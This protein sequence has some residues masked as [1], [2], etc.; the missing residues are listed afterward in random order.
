MYVYVLYLFNH[1]YEFIYI[2]ESYLWIL[3]ACTHTHT[4]I[5]VEFEMENTHELIANDLRSRE[6][7]LRDKSD[8]TMVS[9]LRSREY[10][11]EESDLNSLRSRESY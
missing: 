8:P 5:K 7:L 3:Y 1:I 2:N 9:C 10:F 11:W 4:H 6:S